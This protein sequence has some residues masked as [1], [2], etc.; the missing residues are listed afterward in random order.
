MPD[1][2]DPFFTTISRPAAPTPPPVEAEPKVRKKR[3]TKEEKEAAEPAPKLAE[4]ATSN[5]DRWKL[6]PQPPQTVKARLPQYRVKLESRTYPPEIKYHEAFART[7]SQAR[8]HA[9]AAHP[10]WDAK[11]AILIAE[12]IGN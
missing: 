3:A 10:K 6:P 4:R 7:P 5:S 12:G 9:E 2:R 8:T 1:Q 11:T